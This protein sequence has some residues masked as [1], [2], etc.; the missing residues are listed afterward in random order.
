MDSVAQQPKSEQQTASSH[1]AAVSEVILAWSRVFQGLQA[2]LR[3]NVSVV[4]SDLHLSLKAIVVTLFCILALV[5]IVLVVWVTLLA[6][7]AYGLTTFGVH[8]LWSLTLVV[9]FN[10][11]ALIVIK[12]ML[13]TAF[14]AIKMKT[15]AALLFNSGQQQ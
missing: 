10:I 4:A 9:I 13:T 7:M 6:G 8:W 1:E 3:T 12:G 2:Q 5:S 15:T 11:A 14:H